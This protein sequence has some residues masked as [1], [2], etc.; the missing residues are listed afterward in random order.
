MKAVQLSRFGN[1]DVLQV[2]E[3]PTPR[4]EP[5]EV[6]ARIHAAGVNFFEILLRQNQYAVTPELPMILGVEI[7]GIVEALGEGVNGDWMGNRVA[8]PMFAFG[9]A[10]A[11]MPSLWR[12]APRA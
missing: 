10:T 4:P 9:P 3:V 8:V 12:S 11:D 5:G 7:A 6:L 2:I 1:P